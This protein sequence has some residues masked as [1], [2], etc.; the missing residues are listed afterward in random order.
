MSTASF[1]ALAPE[2]RNR[3]YAFYFVDTPAGSTVPITN[4]PLALALTCRQLYNETCALAFPATIFLT[5][6][7]S[8]VELLA[9]VERLR[10]NLRPAVEGLEL[11]IGVSDFLT[12]PRSLDGLR[13]ADAGL[14]G[15]KE[16]H[17]RFSGGPQPWER[18]V[19]IG[20]NLE[21]V[22]WKTVAYCKN[23][24]LKTIRLVHHG[25]IRKLDMVRLSGGMRKKLPLRW[26]PTMVWEVR[27]N[28]QDE[29]F[30]L[31]HNPGQGLEPR[32]VSISLV[33]VSPGESLD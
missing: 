19:Y 8:L 12:H 27:S 14:R 28:P 25:A 13:F 26:A 3:V 31:V 33:E 24:S 7:W 18:E 30:E 9:K 29:Y 20:Y 6:C 15:L 4:S 22:L 10:P 32:I 2:L 17:I 16:L 23:E 21:I 5:K 1:L 11:A